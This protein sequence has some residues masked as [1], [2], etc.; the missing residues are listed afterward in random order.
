MQGKLGLSL[1][2][3]L[4]DMEVELDKYCACFCLLMPS[5]IFSDQINTHT[6]DIQPCECD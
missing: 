6:F 4:P 2:D 3:K 5:P 1:R